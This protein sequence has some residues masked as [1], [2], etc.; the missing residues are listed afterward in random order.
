MPEPS[1]SAEAHGASPGQARAELHRI[2]E[3]LTDEEATALWRLICS[4]VA[5]GPTARPPRRASPE[6]P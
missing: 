3:Q 5:E 4:W 2:I 1:A 6:Q